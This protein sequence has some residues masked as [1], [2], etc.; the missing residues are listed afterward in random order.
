MPLIG[1]KNELLNNELQII[2]LKGLPLKTNWNLIWH[3]QKS[4]SPVAKAYLD[5]IK[6]NKT[7]IIETKFK[8]YEK[9]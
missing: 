5:F 4:L 9:Y 1:L 2:P 6:E 8:W 7:Q 3:K